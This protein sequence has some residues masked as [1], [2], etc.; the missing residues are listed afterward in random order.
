MSDS[1]SETATD[2][3]KRFKRTL[4]VEDDPHL[5]KALTSSLDSYSSEI[6]VCCTINEAETVIEDW[7][8]DLMFLDFKLSDG[9]ALDL[10]GKISQR[11]PYPIIIAIS[12]Y[13]LP[14]E[15]FQLARFGVRTFLQK[16]I[17]LADL[18][19]TLDRVSADIPNLVPH[20]RTAVG[21]IS[22]KEVEQC[23]RQTMLEEALGRVDGSR[24]GAAKLLQVSR[25][26]I[27]HVVNKFT[28]K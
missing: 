18:E 22:L 8:P 17:N 27:Q 26:F 15:T 24:R 13:A 28:I 3:Q 11:S 5:C 23:V 19:A 14:E 9:I 21:A 7:H 6:R 20:I 2:K 16:P 12:A 10:L 4:V 1:A 25:Q